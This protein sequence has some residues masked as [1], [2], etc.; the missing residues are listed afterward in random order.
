MARPRKEINQE[1]FE[2]LCA[3]MCTKP[4][5]AGWF[6]VSEDTIERWCVRTYEEGY[7]ECFKKFSAPGKTSLRRKQY[8][9][10]MGGHV[11]MLIWLGKQFLGQSDKIIHAEGDVKNI[12]QLNYGRKNKE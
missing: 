12:L 1:D 3:I 9:V 8:E 4:E 5:M 10:A 2:K 11:T 7:A 6:N